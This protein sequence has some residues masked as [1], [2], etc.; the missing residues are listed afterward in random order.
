MVLGVWGLGFGVWGLGF[1]VWCLGFGVWGLGFSVWGL[2][3]GDW[4]LGFT[5]NPRISAFVDSMLLSPDLDQLGSDQ[6][7]RNERKGIEEVWDVA[8]YTNSP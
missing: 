1:G 5:E 3:S 8:P 2:G 6:S 7:F 4:G